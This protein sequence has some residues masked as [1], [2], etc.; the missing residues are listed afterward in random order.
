MPRKATFPVLK[1]PISKGEMHIL[2]TVW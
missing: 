2:K 1:V